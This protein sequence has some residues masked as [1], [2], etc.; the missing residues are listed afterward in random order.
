MTKTK[1]R[2]T[3]R[4]KEA[5]NGNDTKPAEEIE[6]TLSGSQLRKIKYKKI[7]KQQEIARAMEERKAA[8]DGNLSPKGNAVV[9]KSAKREPKK[10]LITHA[11]KPS[12]K[13]KMDEVLN[14]MMRKNVN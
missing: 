3:L 1:K 10:H 14:R 5:T 6:T 4:D 2:L 13:D 9:K 7:H 12:D 8:K 11:P